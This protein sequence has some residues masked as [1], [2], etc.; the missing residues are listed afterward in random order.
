MDTSSIMRETRK[1]KS[2]FEI[3]L[4]RR[5]GEIGR[6]VYARQKRFLKRE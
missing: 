6:R 2:L 5:A 1:I 3:D 4:M